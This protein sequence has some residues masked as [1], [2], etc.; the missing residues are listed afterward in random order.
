MNSQ[1]PQ[2]A[3]GPLGMDDAQVEQAL[4]SLADHDIT[5]HAGIYERLL[6]GLQQELNRTEHG[7]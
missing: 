3:P 6:D 2:P 1:N 4:S 7:R 5:E